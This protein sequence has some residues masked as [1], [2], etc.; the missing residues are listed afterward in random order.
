[1]YETGNTR[2]IEVSLG[3]MSAGIFAIIFV[4]IFNGFL[5]TKFEDPNE[6][7]KEK[8]ERKEEQLE[9]KEEQLRKIEEQ[10]KARRKFN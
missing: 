9:G 10:L 3:V 6:K 8:L 2:P 7:L 4:Q 5:F 1:M